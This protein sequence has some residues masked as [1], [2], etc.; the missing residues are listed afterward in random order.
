VKRWK[1]AILGVAL[2]C[3]L[4]WAMG[5]GVSVRAQDAIHIL[6]EDVT[7]SYPRL[8]NFDLSA[9]SSAAPITSVRLLWQVGPEAAFNV[10]A[11]RFR[12]SQQVEVAYPLN[13]QFLSIPPFGQISYR[14]QIRDEQGN[15]LITE[16]RTVEYEDTR[17]NWQE[18][19][20]DHL[21]LLWYGYDE[22]FANEL[23]TIVDD[24]YVRLETAFGVDLPRKPTVVIYSDRQT[25]AEFQGMMS[26]VEFVIGRYFP[27]H[28]ITVNLVTEDMPHDVY[29][30]TLAHELSHLYSDNFYV[31]YSRIPL[32]LEEGLATYN[33]SVNPASKLKSVRQAASRGD[34]VPFIDLPAAI[35][36]ANIGVTNLAYA[37]GATVFQFINAQWG[38]AKLV[39]FLSAFRGTTSLDNVTTRVFEMN[40]VDFELAWRAWLGFPVDEVPQLWP[41]PTLAPYEFPTP[42]FIAPGQT[43]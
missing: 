13:A 8:V 10:Q 1:L 9:T 35:R 25:F 29:A 5:T 27:G 34:L 23:F 18:L 32:W 22:A 6:A 38:E 41:T 4:A 26:N 37:E 31:G 40:S 21:R 14:W 39:E 11:L 28:N 30:E 16:N 17:N 7:V 15:E 33:E 3:G 12:A 42:A 24:A 2:V 43:G 19:S 36:D 20:N